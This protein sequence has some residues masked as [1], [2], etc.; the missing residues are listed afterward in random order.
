LTAQRSD[1]CDLFSNTLQERPTSGE[2]PA[3]AITYAQRLSN[4][5]ER[6]AIKGAP[7]LRAIKRRTK[8]R[9]STDMWVGAIAP[10]CGDLHCHR[11]PPI[12]RWISKCRSNRQGRLSGRGEAAAHGDQ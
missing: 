5:E 6:A 11:A 9:R 3:Q 4:G 2:L 8:V 12:S 1:W 7:L 10:Q